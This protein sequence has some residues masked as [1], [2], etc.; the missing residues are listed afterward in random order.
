MRSASLLTLSATLLAP[1][2]A[3]GAPEDRGP[4]TPAIFE[5][6]SLTIAGVQIPTRVY[7]PTNATAPGALLIMMHGNL[8]NGSYHEELAQTLASRGFVLVLPDMPCGLGGCNHDENATQLSGLLEWAAAQN[9]E[10]SSPIFG[11]ANAKRGLLGHS[12]GGLGVFLATA[13]DPSVDAVVLFDPKD[14]LGAAQTEQA[15]IQVPS[16]HLMAEVRGLCN[17]DWA[18]AVYPNT[19][20]PH[21]RLRVVGSGHCDVEEPS[22]QLCPFA[23]GSG[24]GGSAIF[25]RYAVAF[26]GCVLH[27]DPAMEPYLA[28]S[29]MGQDI[30]GG[31]ITLVDHAGLENLGCRNSTTAP[32]LLDA[33]VS[34]PDASNADANTPAPDAGLVSA[35]AGDPIGG[36]RPP[37]DAGTA[38]AESDGCRCITA[39]RATGWMILALALPLL[40]RRRRR[41]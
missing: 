15:N 2:A 16:A 5:A 8:R 29:A 22:D 7:Y 19:A 4:Y 36:F 38:G 11:K 24:N 10:A 32:P 37:R 21:L 9:A 39:G 14:D 18:T 41:S 23:C 12:Y 40:L 3:L 34:R 27:E 6:G 26:M 1:L 35:D 13:R 33:G 31:I 30:A 20:S 28:G 17:D 25:R